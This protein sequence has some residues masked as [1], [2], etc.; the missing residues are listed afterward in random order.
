[1]FHFICT[2][3]LLFIVISMLWPDQRKKQAA[4]DRKHNGLLA[5][6]SKMER[7]I[8]TLVP[9]PPTPLSTPAPIVNA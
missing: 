5:T 4:A 7:Q 9:A 6:I 2:S 8:A 3:I 1:M